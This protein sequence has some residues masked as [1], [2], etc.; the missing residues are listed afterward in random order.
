MQVLTTH[1]KHEEELVERGIL[2]PGAALS[3]NS[4][5]SAGSGG[6]GDSNG[7]RLPKL[8]LK[9]FRGA[10]MMMCGTSVLS[11]KCCGSTSNLWSR[12]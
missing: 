7:V 1:Q 11:K 5:T 6:S 3:S 4:G 12:L 9:E 8:Q 10:M 2:P